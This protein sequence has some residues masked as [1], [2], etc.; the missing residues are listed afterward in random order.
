MSPK[1]KRAGKTKLVIDASVALKWQL[2]DEECVLQAVALRDDCLKKSVEMCAPT[3]WL[4]ET[5]NGFIVASR[6]GR[7]PSAEVSQ[8]LRDLFAIGVKLRTPDP[9]RVAALALAHEIT[10]Y[11]SAY[12]ALAEQE[13][14]DLW[15]GDLAFYRAVGKKLRWVHWIG[16]YSAI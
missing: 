9:Q 16:E 8:A 1:A 7:F 14:C 5:V 13:G 15:T 11:D 10:A 12:L 3:L 2:D 4:Y 6:R